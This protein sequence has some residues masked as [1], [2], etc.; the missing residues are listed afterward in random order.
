MSDISTHPLTED[1]WPEVLAADVRAFGD[2]LADHD[3]DITWA[4]LDTDR[5]RIA[6]D[7]STNDVVGVVGVHTME[8]TLPGTR[9]EHARTIPMGGLTWVSVAP[10]HRR[11]G[12]LTSLIRQVHDTSIDR[13][14]PL[15]GLWA[16][17]SG[18]YERFGYG[19]A[20]QALGG[21][22]RRAGAA[23][24]QP[25]TDG[26]GPVRL[27]NAKDEVDTLVDL[28]DRHRQG[29]P[30]EVTR[31]R[32]AFVKDHASMKADPHVA[33]HADGYAVWTMKGEWDDHGVPAGKLTLMDFC[34]ITPEAHEALW[35]TILAVDL[36]ATIEFGVCFRANDPLAWLLTDPRQVRISTVWDGL[37]LRVTDPVA[38]FDARGYRTDGS[39]VLEVAPLDDRT[40]PTRVL[41]ADGGAQATDAEPDLLVSAPAAGSLLLGAVSA[42][43]LAAA[44]RVAEQTPGALGAA[45]ALLGWSPTASCGVIF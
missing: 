20:T 22:I 38:C 35:R 7:D 17:E 26:L 12:V 18:I 2:T 44:D 8:L 9:P 40:E 33:L 45:D 32:A 11:R 29:A 27:A 41:L 28:W 23:F 4:A 14:E 6:R 42:S 13:G 1:D 43:E 10:T 25:A 15:M 21:E 3:P 37:W 19:M 31:P 30:G 24:R 16:S 5:F 34:A 36:V 39:L